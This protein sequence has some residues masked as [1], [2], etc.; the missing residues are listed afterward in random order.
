MIRLVKLNSG[1]LLKRKKK[2]TVKTK[3]FNRSVELIP[4]KNNKPIAI[5]YYKSEKIPLGYFTR[6]K[7]SLGSSVYYNPTLHRRQIGKGG[8][9]AVAKLLR[10]SSFKSGTSAKLK[11]FIATMPKSGH[12]GVFQRNPGMKRG[13]KGEISQKMGAS[14]P[15]MV[16]NQKRVYGIVEPDIRK[17]L[18]EA[19]NRHVIRALKNEI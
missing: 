10:D 6:R 9:G 4:A 18:K 2:Y 1:L 3:G 12:T 14:I 19:V 8:R 16:G 5:L 13:D 17:D 15:E 11:W 7:G